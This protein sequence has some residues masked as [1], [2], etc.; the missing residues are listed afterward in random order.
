M[1]KEKFQEI[2][3]LTRK[4]YTERY[5]KLGKD[6][7]TLGWGSIEQQWYRFS[8]TLSDNLKFKDKQILDIGCGFGDYFNF[9]NEQNIEINSYIGWDSNEKFINEA[10]E[11]ISNKDTSFEIKDVLKLTENEPIADIVVMLGLLNWKLDDKEMN[12]EYSEQIISNAFKVTRECL[13]VD[14]LSTKLTSDYPKEDFVFYH[15]P[16]RMLDFALS[17]TNNVELKH[18]YEPIP[19]KEFMLFIYK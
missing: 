7:R 14:F 10:R 9:I 11:N 6:I 8:Q 1:E 2:S 12:Y 4:R 18:N 19:Q 15:E 13:I 17:L 16:E 3:K 5:E